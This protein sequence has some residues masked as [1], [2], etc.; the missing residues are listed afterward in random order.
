MGNSASI[1]PWSRTYERIKERH[2]AAYRAIDTAITL[3]EQEKPHEV[4]WKFLR[5]IS[6][7]CIVIKRV[8]LFLL[9]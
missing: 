5:L 2:D 3:E 7:Y 6:R 8:Q 4:I 9:Q 1:S